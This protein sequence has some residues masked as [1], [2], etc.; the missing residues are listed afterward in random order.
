MCVH[1]YIHI[2]KYTHTH[3]YMRE[4]DKAN[5]LKCQQLRNLGEGYVRVLWATLTTYL[6]A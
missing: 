6:E 2:Q 5:M 3:T 1:T 4:T